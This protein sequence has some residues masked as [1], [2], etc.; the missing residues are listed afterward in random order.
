MAAL[1][2]V[3]LPVDG[4]PSGEPEGTLFTSGFPEGRGHAAD[5]I[6]VEAGVLCTP[7]VPE[8]VSRQCSSGELATTPVGRSDACASRHPEKGRVLSEGCS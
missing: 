7:H 3:G 5:V 4:E 6:R 1:V 2:A 8:L